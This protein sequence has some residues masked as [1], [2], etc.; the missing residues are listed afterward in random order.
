MEYARAFVKITAGMMYI[1]MEIV[2]S[3]SA[4]ATE[5]P[6][7]THTS[8]AVRPIYSQICPVRILYSMVG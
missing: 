7:P 8:Y 3:S 5:C 2:V 1:D 4:G 6:V